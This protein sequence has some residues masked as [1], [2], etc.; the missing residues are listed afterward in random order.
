LLTSVGRTS[1]KSIQLLPAVVIL[2]W[3]D[4]IKWVDATCEQFL[5]KTDRFRP[6]HDLKALGTSN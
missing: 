3:P 6:F 2:P 5:L 1:E 4:L